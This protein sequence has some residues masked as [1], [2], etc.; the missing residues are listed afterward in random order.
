MEP[1]HIDPSTHDSAND[2]DGVPTESDVEAMFASSCD[3]GEIATESAEIDDLATDPIQ[4]DAP[5]LT[6]PDL[7]H[8]SP[9]TSLN[10]LSIANDQPTKESHQPT[11]EPHQPTKEPHQPTKEPHQPTTTNGQIHPEPKAVS[12]SISFD[13]PCASTQHPSAKT[14]VFGAKAE[15]KSSQQTSASDIESKLAEAERRRKEIRERKVSRAKMSIQ[16]TMQIN[17]VRQEM[18]VSAFAPKTSFVD[19]EHYAQARERAMQQLLLIDE[20]IQK[21]LPKVA[22]CKTVAHSKASRLPHESRRG[23]I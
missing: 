19:S 4:L 5:S 14:L 21:P 6:P 12:F 9:T 8:T 11:K 17:S 13:E 23:T 3:E 18:G 2:A 15:K 20:R 22:A 1:Q 16:R 7:L 10:R